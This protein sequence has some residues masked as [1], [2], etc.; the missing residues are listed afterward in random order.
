MDVVHGLVFVCFFLIALCAISHYFRNSPLPVV[1]W[2]VLFGTGYGIVQK[3]TLTELPWIR[4]S[5]D[6]ILYILLPVL[7]FDSSRK[8]RMKIA[9]RVALP[10][11]LLATLGILLSMFAM[12]LPIRL[13]TDLPWMDVLFFCAIMSATDPVAVSAI[14]KVFP[15]PEKLK[16]LVEGESLLNDGTTVILF[17]LMFG[18]VVEGHELL[19]SQGVLKFVLSMGAAILMGMA[20]GWACMALMRNWKAL[21]SHFIGP[22]MPLLFVYLVFCAAQAGLDVSGVMAVMAATI[23]M[24]LVLLKYPKEIMP[25]RELVEFDRD[26][27]NFLSELANSILF[28]MLGA[29]I[30]AHSCEFH[31]RLLLISLASLLMARSVVV[32]GFGAALRL[33]RIRI[34]LAWQHV[35]NLGGLKGA[36]SVALVLMIPQDYA[37]RNLFLLAALVMCL[38]TLVFNT[39]GLRVYMKKADLG[40]AG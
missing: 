11:V 31:W 15:V 36:L 7:I 29:E 23:T 18:K 24:K 38:F 22:L 27:W 14:F 30:G 37:Y 40:E 10:S 28:F 34:P 5:P 4:L 25:G 26:F 39:L 35:L 19:F 33:V 8:L 16:M 21:K 20:A 3:F 6:V 17:S 9:L 2:V 13:L 32:Y 12:A 1:C